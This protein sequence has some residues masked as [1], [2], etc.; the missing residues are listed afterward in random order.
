MKAQSSDLVNFVNF[1]R[2][3]YLGR[4]CSEDMVVG[5]WPL[6]SEENLS[7]PTQPPN[8]HRKRRRLHALSKENCK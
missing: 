5:K 4:I 8:Q 6:A 7:P 1:A 3:D 2:V